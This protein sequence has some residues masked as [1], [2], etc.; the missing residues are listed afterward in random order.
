MHEDRVRAGSFGEDPALYDRARPSYP[1]ELVDALVAGAPRDVLD[2]GCGTGIAGRLFASRQCRVLGGEPDERMAAV[3]RHH[4]LT[5]ECATFEAWDPRDRQFDLVVSGQA[6][7]W[8]E[9]E[10]GARKAAAVLRPGGAVG[11]FWNQ[12]QPVGDVRA[13]L[14]G[15]YHRRAPGLEAYSILL[16]PLGRERFEA[17]AAA[18]AAT[19]CFSAPA[20]TAYGWS[21]RYT[22]GQWIDH[23][24]THSDHRTM[25]AEAR[26]PLLEDIGAVVDRFG[27]SMQIDYTCWLVTARRVGSGG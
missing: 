25:P 23:L 18:L 16:R 26:T 12:G 20:V 19:G 4:G 1:D 14:D 17:A 27:G 24:L 13:A 7:H 3:A 11:L 22:T 21:Q 15:V 2:V 10:A 8:V 6:W 9:P 5:V